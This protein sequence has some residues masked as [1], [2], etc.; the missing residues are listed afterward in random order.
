VT[1]ECQE[2]RRGS[3]CRCGN[4]GYGLG[5]TVRNRPLFQVVTAEPT[6]KT[7]RQPQQK[8]K[9][10]RRRECEVRA[11][12]AKL[13]LGATRARQI[14]M[15]SYG[16]TLESLECTRVTKFST[17]LFTVLFTEPV[18]S[19]QVQKHG[20]NVSASHF[21]PFSAYEKVHSLLS[22]ILERHMLSSSTDFCLSLSRSII[23]TTTVSLHEIRSE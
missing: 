16:R 1:Q 11:G 3:R 13:Q 12:G 17:Y 10:S 9:P 18:K 8:C 23:E 14:L 20:G 15:L 5:R 6:S 19:D 21:L 22:Y 7:P 4:C 2:K